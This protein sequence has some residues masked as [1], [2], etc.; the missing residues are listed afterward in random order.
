MSLIKLFWS[1]V[2]KIDQ[3]GQA[4]TTCIA[5]LFQ[6]QF[7]WEKNKC[8]A[9]IS[10]S[11]YFNQIR[12]GGANLQLF[13]LAVIFFS[14]VIENVGV[15]LPV[16]ASYILAAS[17]IKDGHSYFFMLTVLTMA[18]LAG[19]IIAYGLGCWGEG[20]LTRHLQKRPRFIKASQAIHRWYAQHGKATVFATRFI[21]YVRPWSSLVAGFAHVNFPSFVFYT[22]SGSFLFN[23]IVLVCTKYLLNLW[24]QYGYWFKVSS[25]TLC[26]M[27][28]GALFFAH[29]FYLKSDK[30]EPVREIQ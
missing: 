18:H 28:F 14:I 12:R 20:W 16:E 21:G 15:P 22:L 10:C 1:Y 5:I 6:A 23:I 2:D 11:H 25:V 27:S 29:R 9:S 19:S 30:D 24:Y 8:D 3:T 26:L 13:K 17:L 7:N 4:V